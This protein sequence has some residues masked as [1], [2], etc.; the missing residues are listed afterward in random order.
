MSIE[1]IFSTW[2]CRHP[3]PVDFVGLP[4]MSDQVYE[5]LARV[6]GIT[7]V[8]LFKIVIS[9]DIVPN[10]IKKRDKLLVTLTID[11]CELYE[12]E[13]RCSQGLALEKV[14]SVIKVIK[15]FTI[16]LIYHRWKLLDI[17]NHHDL[18][19]T[20]RPLNMSDGPKTRVNVIQ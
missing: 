5:I 17:A 13:V 9:N 14:S 10:S 7:L 11:R 19:A 1:D 8:N 6:I 18:N 16:T 2:K 12:K 15:N 4:T 3:F 20:K